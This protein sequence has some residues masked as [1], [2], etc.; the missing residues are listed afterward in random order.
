M[1]K[2]TGLTEEQ[3]KDHPEWEKQCPQCSG[4]KLSRSLESEDLPYGDKGVV[5]KCLVPV[6][7]CH[8]CEF[9]WTNWEAEDIHEKT[10]EAYKR[11]NPG[12]A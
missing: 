8:E 3:L 9:E 4:D 7:S 12:K 2:L 5:L 1:P 11:E 10:I 6:Y